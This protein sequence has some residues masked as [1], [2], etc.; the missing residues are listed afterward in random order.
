M[1]VRATVSVAIDTLH[2]VIAR[3][4]GAPVNPWSSFSSST[5]SA[6]HGPD[7]LSLA[8]NTLLSPFVHD[9]AILSQHRPL[10]PS[11]VVCPQCLPSAQ[12]PHLSFISSHVSRYVPLSSETYWQIK[13]DSLT[14]GS[15]SSNCTNAVLD[16]GTS[17]LAGPTKEVEAI[18]RAIGARPF[19]NGEY[20]VPCKSVDSLPDLVVTIAGKQ[21]SI[22]AKD[23]VINDENQICLFGA[24]CP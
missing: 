10:K 3:T 21:Y 5:F 6:T 17:L 13:I 14:I 15:A 18:A 20:T 9:H 19:T 11:S 7:T 16:T 8:V 4:M 22:K 23:Y 1:P 24:F 12:H 2:R